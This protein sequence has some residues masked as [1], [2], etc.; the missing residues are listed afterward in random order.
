M[1]GAKDLDQGLQLSQ[2]VRKGGQG[3]K[4]QGKGN[5]VFHG[6][7]ITLGP[8]K[9]KVRIA[10]PGLPLQLGAPVGDRPMAEHGADLT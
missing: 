2:R 5:D 1:V 6:V 8:R 10:C 4:D 7:T 3:G 9:G